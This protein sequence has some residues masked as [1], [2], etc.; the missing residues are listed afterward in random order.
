M[1]LFYV[2]VAGAKTRFLRPAQKTSS[3]NQAKRIC[4]L[5]CKDASADC[6]AGASQVRSIA[7]SA[8]AIAVKPARSIPATF[9]AN[10]RRRA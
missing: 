5:A 1:L 3:D 2:F 7:R 8:T 9:C 4:K 10:Q 6:S